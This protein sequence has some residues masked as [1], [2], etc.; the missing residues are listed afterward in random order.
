MVGLGWPFRSP[1]RFERTAG[2][3][4]DGNTQ[5]LTGSGTTVRQT[6]NVLVAFSYFLTD[7][8]SADFGIGIPPSIRLEGDGTF[9]GL[10]E[11]GRAKFNSPAVILKYNF[12]AKSDLLRPAVGLGLSY[13]WYSN[14][15]LSPTIATG[16]FLAAPESGNALVGP[17]TA[18]VNS[19]FAPVVSASLSYEFSSRWIAGVSLVYTPVSSKTTLTTNAPIGTVTSVE[20]FKMNTVTTLV[21]VGYVF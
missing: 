21:S 1:Q 11:L 14:I 17:T 12:G 5:T 8:V 6:E 7:H 16:Q 13:V 10:G 15:E 18:K 9:G 19:S 4:C 20:K 3:H 2:S